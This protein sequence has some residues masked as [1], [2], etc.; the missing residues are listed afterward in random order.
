MS[1]RDAKA[2]AAVPC[3]VCL[4]MVGEPCRPGNEAEFA[5]FA[6]RLWVHGTRRKAW[7][8]HRWTRGA[9]VYAQPDGSSPGG[10]GGLL[11][12]TSPAAYE[13]ASL[14]PDAAVDGDYV[15]V[16][17]LRAAIDALTADGWVVE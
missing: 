15:W 8:E 10:R 5:T 14:L 9:D 2:I 1:R 6:G 16:P 12:A 11:S 17:N 13:A 7:Q 3:P 4:A